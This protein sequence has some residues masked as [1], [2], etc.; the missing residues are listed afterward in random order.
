MPRGVYKRKTQVQARPTPKVPAAA[1]ETALLLPEDATELVIPDM[2]EVEKLVPAEAFAAMPGW[3][4]LNPDEQSTTIEEGELLAQ[5][6]LSYGKSRMAIGQHLTKLRSVLEPHNLFTRFLKN[7]HFSKRTAYRYIAG[8]ENAK[9][10]LPEAILNVAMARGVNIIGESEIKP[11]GI[12]TEAV[13]KLPPPAHPTTEQANTWLTQV[14]QVRKDTKTA[15]SAGFVM[16]APIDTTMALKESFRFISSRY[17]RLPSNSK[18]RSAFVRALV[19]M[20]L[21]ELGVAGPQTFSP[22]AV[23]E[24]F[25]AQRGRPREI[26]ATA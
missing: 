17:K 3:D 12:Y 9:A 13:K 11:L 1:A 14:E 23:P 20:I 7:F 4:K 10:R 15:A 8:Y 22:T 18:V 19:G 5:A 26:A 16:P 24:D 6:L 2:G 21:T 25:R